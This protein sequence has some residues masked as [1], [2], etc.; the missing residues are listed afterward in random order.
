[1]LLTKEISDS[2]SAEFAN[3]KPG[4]AYKLSVS[5]M[6][7]IQHRNVTED[8]S[9]ATSKSSPAYIQLLTLPSPPPAPTL[10][11]VSYHYCFINWSPPTKLADGASITDY[12]V[13]YTIMNNNGSKII[14]G[15]GMVQLSLNRKFVMLKG[16]VQGTTYAIQVKVINCFDVSNTK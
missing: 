5:A 13:K 12:Q 8:P 4:T 11:N 15:T 7:N 14:Y 9:A 16:L 3:V 6:A 2:M 10:L 1:M